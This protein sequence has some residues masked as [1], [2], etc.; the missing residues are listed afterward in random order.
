MK[1][2]SFYILGQKGYRCLSDFII[3]FGPSR[4]AYVVSCRDTNNK[5]DYFEESQALCLS[6]NILFKERTEENPKLTSVSFAIGWRWLIHGEDSLIV[7]HDSLLPKYRGFA[8]MVNA[9]INGESEIGVSVIYA[10]NE[11]DAGPI[12]KQKSME[13]SYPKKISSAIA[14]IS[15]LYSMI[16]LE[17]CKDIYA[18]RA[19]ECV[20]QNH[21]SASYSPWRDYDDYYIDWSHSASHI[22][23]F[24]DAVGHP[25]A[26]A[27]TMMGEA[28]VTILE[29]LPRKDL[30]IESRGSHIGKVLFLDG[31]KPTI[32]CGSGLIQLVDVLDMEGSSLINK[33]PF[34]TRFGSRFWK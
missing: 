17:I 34:R 20:E 9:L 19:L 5:E 2:F 8:P 22:C 14:E 23:R 31:G 18:G 11:Y 30:E 1:K 21:E 6:N 26:G 33:I 16:L 27:R 13:I 32:I 28:E 10:S 25:Y 3:E 15:P 7:F 24:I 4:V 12:I 29:A